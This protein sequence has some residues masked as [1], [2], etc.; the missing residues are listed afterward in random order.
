MSYLL[1]RFKVAYTCGPFY[2][3]RY[4]WAPNNGSAK[5]CVRT[6]ISPTLFPE[7]L[8]EVPPEKVAPYPVLMEGAYD[9]AKVI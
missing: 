3:T 5:S 4:V 8:G 2:G 6:R 9:P 7:L 1:R